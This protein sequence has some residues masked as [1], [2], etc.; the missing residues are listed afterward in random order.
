[1]FS[2]AANLRSTPAN[3]KKHLQKFVS[4]SNLRPTKSGSARHARLQS[5]RLTADRSVVL[6]HLV[7]LFLSRQVM[8][9]EA[10]AVSKINGT[11]QNEVKC[12]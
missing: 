4:A 7:S 3:R 9:R 12:T 1:M 8:M 10:F 5:N 11:E 2:S 6:L